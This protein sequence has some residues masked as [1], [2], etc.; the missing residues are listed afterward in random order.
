MVTTLPGVVLGTAAYM[1]PEQV[2]G[3]GVDGRS[4]IF[5]LGVLLFEMAT[6]RSPFQRENF[7]DSLHAVAF[8]DAPSLGSLDAHLPEELHRIVLRCLRKDPAE[9]YGEAQR[10]ADDLRLLRRNAESGLAGKTS[11][12]VRLSDAWERLCSLRP[13]QYVGVILG[14]TAGGAA[15]YLSVSRIGTGGM[16]C[17]AFA[18]LYLYR[19]IR[20][21]PHRMQETFVRRVAKVPEVLLIVLQGNQFTILVERPTSQL[22][23]RINQHLR[24]CNRKLYFGPSLTVAIQQHV[25]PESTQRLLFG[26][27]V[28]FVRQDLLP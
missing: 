19:F 8:D 17:L 27:G 14:A 7:M 21:R 4:D 20:N 24:M 2:R 26:P 25:S 3:I 28:Q 11:W 5:S 10:L 23:T 15:L 22:Y 9:R 18:V 12:R 6:G 13:S 1:S 16:L